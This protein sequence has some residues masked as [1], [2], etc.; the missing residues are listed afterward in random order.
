MT[1]ITIE[2]SSSDV[3]TTTDVS[4]AST[5]AAGHTA[6]AASGTGSAPADLLAQAAAVGALNAG[7]APSLSG[8]MM[9]TAPV[10]ASLGGSDAALQPASGGAAPEHLFETQ[11]S[12]AQGENR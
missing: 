7:P 9:G 12:H 1:K 6:T 10:A 8:A 11:Q 3:Q 5:S 2:I 4:G